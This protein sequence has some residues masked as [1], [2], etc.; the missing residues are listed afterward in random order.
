MPE[1]MTGAEPFPVRFRS[2]SHIDDRAVLEA[3]DLSFAADEPPIQDL[4]AD[5]IGDGEEVDLLGLRNAEFEEELFGRARKRSFL[6]D[7]SEPQ[8]SF[9]EAVEIVVGF[10]ASI[11]RRYGH[12]AGDAML[13]TAPDRT[14]NASFPAVESRF[15]Q[16]ALAPCRGSVVPRAFTRAKAASFFRWSAVSVSNAAALGD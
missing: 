13:F 1:L 10:D 7:K 12:V 15:S 2:I 14:S 11:S 3:D 4:R 9:E 16:R 8:T 6:V 5:T